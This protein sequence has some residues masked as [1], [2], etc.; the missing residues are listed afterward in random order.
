[1]EGTIFRKFCILILMLFAQAVVAYAGDTSDRKGTPIRIQASR[2]D[3]YNEEKKIIFSGDV[4]A[5]KAEM[6][7]YA[8]QMTVY[9]RK[10]EGK[11]AGQGGD[12][13]EVEK[14]FA[15][16]HVRIVK[17]NRTATGDDAVYY[18]AEQNVILTGNPRV[19]EGNNMVKGDKITIFLDEDRS[20]VESQEGNR[21]EAI[22]YPK[23]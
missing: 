1:M 10:T 14:I 6:T 22:V 20:I 8:D 13:E 19:W 18:S 11:D 3:S 4:V 17:N 7:I 9:Y 12:A 21:V 2:L 16:G 15:K 5:K 23:K